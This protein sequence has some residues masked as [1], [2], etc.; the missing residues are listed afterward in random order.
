MEWKEGRPNDEISSCAHSS[1]L[2][3][4]SLT[5]RRRAHS[6]S[7]LVSFASKTPAS[8]TAKDVTIKVENRATNLLDLSPIPPNGVQV[9]ILIDEGLRTRIGGEIDNLRAFL[10]SLPQGTEVFAGY[11]QNGRVVSADNMPGFTTDRAAAAQGLRLP[12]GLPGASASPYFC[13][14]ELQ[15][16][17]GP[18]APKA[19]TRL[20]PNPR[21]RL[22]SF[23]W[24]PT[25]SIP[26][27]EAPAY[28]TR[29]VPTSPPPSPTP[30]ALA[31]RS[32]PSTT[33]T[34]ASVVAE[35]A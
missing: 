3:F 1:T 25:V 17:T 9:A 19:R 28:S 23:S 33:E 2:L 18:P 30:S 12:L 8:P 24:S 34:Q 13:L 31:S 35:P 11:M 6:Y 5:P 21:I 32:T 26:I 27:T 10:T 7:D 14:S 22:A 4:P 20:S 15:S 16:R 29:T